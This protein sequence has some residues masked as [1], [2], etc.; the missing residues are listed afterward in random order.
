MFCL[1]VV[2]HRDGHPHRQHVT[3]PTGVAGTVFDEDPEAE[4]AAAALTDDQ[5]Q[6][7]SARKASFSLA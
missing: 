5:I 1:V 2:W 6:M 3:K 4:A 7:G